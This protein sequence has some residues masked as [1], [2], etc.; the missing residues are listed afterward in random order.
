M[1]SVGYI[2]S[3]MIIVVWTLRE[4]SRHIISMRKANEKEQKKFKNKLG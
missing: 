1:I 3:R 4:R 2:N